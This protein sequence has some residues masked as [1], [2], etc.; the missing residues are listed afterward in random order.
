M[1]IV[2]LA[3]RRPYTFI[4]MALLILL[5]G[6][7]T[8]QRTPTD[9]FPVI[10]IPVVSVI[11]AYNGISPDDMEKRICTISERA[12]TTTVANIEHIESQSLPGVTVIKFYF[13]PGASVDAGVAQ[14]TSIMQT[15]IRVMPPGITPPLILRY[16]ASSVPILQMSLNSKTLSEQQLFDYGLN[17]VRT[18]MATI[19]GASIPLPYGGKSRQIM[20]DLDTQA[21]QAKG[22]TA[23]DVDNA[24]NAQNLILPAGTAKLGEREYNV[25]LNSSPDAVEALN[26]LPIKVV[27]GAMVT[28]RDVAWVHDGFAVQTNIVNQ[29]GHR[30]AL[31]TVLKSGDA[32]TLSV[33]QR[34]KD[35]LPKIKQT[36]PAAFNMDPLFDQSLF[37]RAAISGVVRE[38]VI[39]ACL[40]AA[41][42][43]LFLGSWRSTFIVAIS[44]PLSILT[45][46]VV[47]GFFGQTMNIMT[48]GG[49]ALAVG[50]LVDDATVTI[51]NIH[52]NLEE[53]K[54]LQRAI[55]DGAHQIATP[56]LV[57]TLS[58]CI[59]FVSV[60]FLTGP[61]KFLFTPLAMAVVF[62]MLASYL[63]SRTL[64]PVLIKLLLNQELHL[65]RET[66]DGSHPVEGDII[67]RVYQVFNRRFMRFREGYRHL[68][69]Y[70]LQHR[71]A[72]V[73]LFV[74][75]F[76][77]SFLLIFLVGQD[78]FPTVDAGQFRLHVRAP[79]GTRIEETERLFHAVE[80]S[81]KQ[82]IPSRELAITID[83][84]GLP[85]SGVNL[86]FSDSSTIGSADGEILVALK[87]EHGPTERYVETLRSTLHKQ[88]PQLTFF[89]QP[90][91]IV[92]QILNFG[93][94]APLDIQ[95]TG[96][97]KGNY[98]IAQ[99]IAA[100]VRQVPGA[101]DVH[102]HQVRNTPA[103]LVNVD[104]ERAQELGLTQQN[105]ASNL[106]I[107]LSSSGQAAPNYWL[108]PK[109]GVSYAVAAQTPQ[110]KLDSIDALE[111]T[112]I[113]DSRSGQDQLLS[114]VATLGRSQSAQVISH[115]NVQP[116]FDIYANIQG[117][118]LG[119]VSRDVQT[120][121]NRFNSKLP[122]G[123]SLALRGQV[124]SMNSSFL[125]LGVGILFAI[126]LVYLL[127]VVNF[128]S[129][130]DPFIIIMALPG[131]LSG[132]LWMLYVTQ[133][134][135]SV[136]S[137]MGTIM[138]IGVATANSI[139]VITFANDRRHEGDDSIQAALAAGYT[140]L[141]PVLMTALAMIIGMLPM[142]LGLGEGGEQNA[143]LGRSVIGGLLMATFTT[144][145]F[146]PV[147]YSVL[148]RRQPQAVEEEELSTQAVVANVPTS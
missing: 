34:I 137:L 133:T 131:A 86:A 125:G 88:F 134:T 114:N 98:A 113:A 54:S 122:R 69:A 23:Q 37:V 87:E 58:I 97:D 109:N 67:W 76:G 128:Q 2:Q 127:M 143:P 39:A 49:L 53:G 68:L 120:I 132:I 121:L 139:L 119:G 146:V 64:V 110:Y 138:C 47:L 142:A 30:A 118:D 50:I 43:L 90:S 82:V 10:D 60:I 108:D 147:V 19:Q 36:L 93:L 129:W 75:F 38:A 21:L 105:V 99:Q 14:L 27:N 63:L 8:I 44:I 117:R 46:I 111:N 141:R 56:T 28:I 85:A 89:F 20:V 42:I 33:V 112:P 71:P 29:N 51:E 22:L 35:A 3:L 84:I 18:Q 31:L 66:A 55:L 81:I 80:N 48:L 73:L 140:R 124:E 144:L 92:S 74:T 135:F 62:A 103:I 4:V 130:L 9:I 24:I 26:N 91:D 70:A 83:N 136:P 59:V 104:R 115:Y 65:Y 40:T 25:F 77:L 61:A 1:W 15:V 13:Q 148:R 6:I 16:S 102:V 72:T 17:F 107:S 126:V 57:A 12:A 94:P 101:V 116:V 5:L 7:V 78:F 79:A 45:S 100:Q 41:M 52:L 32:S 106:L 11:W 96:R 95:V 145:V 123:T